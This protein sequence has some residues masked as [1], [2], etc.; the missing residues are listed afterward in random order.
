MRMRM[1]MRIVHKCLIVIASSFC[2]AS[3]KLG[4]VVGVFCFGKAAEYFSLSLD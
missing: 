3:D 4:S 2:S 1:R